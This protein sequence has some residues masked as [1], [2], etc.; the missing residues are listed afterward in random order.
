[1][2]TRDF[3]KTCPLSFTLTSLKILSQERGITTYLGMTK[4]AHRSF[5]ANYLLDGPFEISQHYPIKLAYR[6][7]TWL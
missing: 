7:L 1:M 3:D 4:G 5:L 6:V 2:P